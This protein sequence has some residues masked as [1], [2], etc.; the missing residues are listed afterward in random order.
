LKRIF[1]R[2]QKIHFI[3]IGGIGMSGIAEVLKNMCF[4]VSGSDIVESSNTRHLSELGIEIFIG[5]E[6]SNIDGAD[7]IVYTSAIDLNNVEFVR[8]KDLHIPVI[9]R[10]EMLAELMRLKYAIAIGG[11]HG[12]TTTTS[13]ISEILKDA[14]LDPTILIGGKLNSTNNNVAYGSSNIMVA[15]ADESDRSFLMLYPSIA[16]ITNIDY[17]HMES[18]KDIEDLQHCFADFAN[19]VPFYGV[20]VLCIDD[21]NV[22]D[23]IPKID[24]RII[25]YGLKTQ[26]DIQAIDIRKK[27]FEVSYNL[28]SYG[29]QLGLI[30]LQLPGDHIV[31]NSLAAVATALE[32]GIDF[33]TIS[34][35]LSKF[36]GVQ[37][38]MTIRYKDDDFTVIDDY[39]H[40][41]TEISITLKAIREAVAD[42]KIVVIFQPHRYS[43]TA[44][45]MS[46]FAK[47]FMDA[48]VLYVT[49]I[50]AASETP[51]VGINS[52]S[53]IKEIKNY[54]F[55]NI[56]Y[57]QN[58]KDMF[59]D[60][61]KDK[62][63]H[64]VYITFGAGSITNFS[65]DLAE[66]FKLLK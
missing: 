65:K 57:L 36:K 20:V 32:M 43:R 54:G 16:V 45:L 59:K 50:Y 41:P 9:K 14:L 58:L 42:S 26:A 51:M 13:M 62:T 3:G 4:D 40:H 31:L 46:E 8:A 10:G 37:R 27:G 49:D 35:S 56:S 47:C 44:A 28:V 17:E 53:L 1:G 63:K 48:D 61:Q 6:E 21:Y 34:E 55:K 66:H 23:I 60:I 5:H 33:N 29:K 52:L 2:V 19:K 18:Y 7:V 38:R 11:S 12:K 22:A 24:K 30:S 15:E 39:G 64:T 25:S